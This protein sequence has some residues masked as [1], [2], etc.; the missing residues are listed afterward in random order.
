MLPQVTVVV[1]GQP[2]WDGYEITEYRVNIT[3]GSD[4]SL[5]E[6]MTVPNVSNRNNSVS[7]NVNQS[8]FESSTQQ[9][10]SLIVSASAVSSQYDGA[11]ELAQFRAPM[12]R[13]KSTQLWLCMHVCTPGTMHET[14][15]VMC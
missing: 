10:Y 11:S 8:L 5:L 7:M 4:G 2:L 9:C 14:W 13:G 12:L 15:P 6:Q 1:T 3:N